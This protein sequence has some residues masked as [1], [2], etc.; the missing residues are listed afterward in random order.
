VL[1][2]RFED[3]QLIDTGWTG[4]VA[5]IVDDR[6]AYKVVVGKPESKRSNRRYSCRLQGNVTISLKAIYTA[7]FDGR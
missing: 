3:N 5:R 6:S 7:A 4:H 1:F 2:A